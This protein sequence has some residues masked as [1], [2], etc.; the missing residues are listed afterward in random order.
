M[1]ANYD[2]SAGIR[3]DTLHWDNL[4]L[5]R[6][7]PFKAGLMFKTLKGNMPSYLQDMFPF[8]G[9][10]YDMRNS[11]ILHSEFFTKCLCGL[12]TKFG[13]FIDVATSRL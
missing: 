5:R 6:E 12:N 2:A 9:T 3:L 13:L 10:G 4:S 1:R 11:E 7:K 8:R